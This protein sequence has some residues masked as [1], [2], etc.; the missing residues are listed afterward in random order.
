MKVSLINYT[1]IGTPD[2]ARFA[3]NQLL[4]TKQTR[5]QMTPGLMD[6]IEV[7]PASKVREELAYM[8]NTIPSSWE[9]VDYT[10]LVEGVSR[11][12]T[13]QQV[14]T[15]TASYAQ[16]TMRV[17]DM[18]SGPG[19]DYLTGPTIPPKE[20]SGLDE[21]WD[22]NGEKLHSLYHGTMALIA[23]AYKDLIAHGAK[24]EDARGIL[25][26]NTLTNIVIKMNMRNFVE[27]VRKRSSS[28][29]Q[30]EYRDVLAGMKERVLEVH[31]FVSM[32]IER[33]FDKAADELDAMI[34]GWPSLNEEYKTRMIKLLD[35]MRVTQ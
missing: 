19:W 8:A 10:W 22:E 35:Q 33:T 11:G 32:F 20:F 6:E 28:R 1:G 25:P 3:A 15:R 21:H 24:I 18:S 29:V 12:Y 31:P 26:T 17:L 7:W 14:R 2:P 30:G 9:F 27:L 34:R 23:D 5:L 13:H 16:Q 4:F